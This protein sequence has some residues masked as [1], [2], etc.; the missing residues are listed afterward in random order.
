V[1][2]CRPT[3][4][5]FRGFFFRMIRKSPTKIV[6]SLFAAMLISIVGCYERNLAPRVEYSQS[7]VET[8]NSEI[9]KMNWE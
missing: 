4:R 2:I 7:D 9:E 6:F 3:S 5:S 1:E 8:L